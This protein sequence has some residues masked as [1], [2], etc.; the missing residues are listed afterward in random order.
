[1]PAASFGRI[2][3]RSFYARPTEVVARELLGRVVAVVAAGAP[4]RLVAGRIVECEA[5]LGRQ[6]PASHAF[7]GP[8]KRAAIM[9]G[10]PGILYVYFT[11]G[12]HHCM[13]VVA[14]R[15]GEPGAV[16][17]RALEPLAGQALA[18]ERRGGRADAALMAGPARLTQALGIDLAWNGADV[19][20]T[21]RRRE[22]IGAIVLREGRRVAD[23]E[24]VRSGRIGIREAADWPL[25]FSVGGSPH[26][27]RP[28]PW[29][30]RLA[31]AGRAGR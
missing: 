31:T 9:F 28:H 21:S 12:M 27:S 20:A 26:V 5:Y 11:Y 1:M 18:R 29:A 8:T 22:A 4:G 19:C 15:D 17:I 10:R 24:V 3:P 2:L 23:A 7:R 30:A 14:E 6:D 25:R 13:N 16:L